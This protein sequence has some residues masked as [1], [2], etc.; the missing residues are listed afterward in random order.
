MRSLRTIFIS[1]II[2]FS[3]Y[4]QNANYLNHSRSIPTAMPFL[5]SQSDARASGMASMGVASSADIFSQ[6]YNSAKYVFMNTNSGIGINYT[7][8][9]SNLT[10]DVFLGGITYFAKHRQKGA[11]ALAFNYFNMGDVELSDIQQDAYLSKG[12]VKPNELTFDLSYNLK[13]S[14]YFSM[15]VTGRWLHSNLRDASQSERKVANS[16]SISLSSYYESDLIYNN[17]FDSRYRL[18][19]CISNIGPKLSYKREGTDFFIPTNLKIGLGYD[20]IFSEIHTLSFLIEFNKLLVPT[21]PIYGFFDL[22]NDGIQ[23]SNE[24]TTIVKGKS[25]NVSFFE[26]IF[27]SFADAPNGFKEE[28]QEISIGSGVEYQLKNDFSLRFGY[29]FESENKGNRSHISVGTGFKY[30]QIKI[31][32]S[33]LF[34]VSSIPNP[35]ESALRFSGSYEY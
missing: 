31:N 5:S 15:G 14:D 30:K 21:P 27:Q 16:V 22:N 4:S 8:F 29:F 20:F 26:G 19:A 17:S 2:C 3:V 13:L 33:Y 18:G 6:Y 35:F 9:L 12:I 28:L 32:L 7:P 34:S 23:N 10:N 1:V 24:P 11:W 25:T